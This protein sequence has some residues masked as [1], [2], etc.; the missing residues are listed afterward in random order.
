M[1]N[2]EQQNWIPYQM[3]DVVD[4]NDAKMSVRNYIEQKDLRCYLSLI[5]NKRKINAA[6]EFGC[7][8]GR[9]TQVLTEFASKVIGLEREQS[10]VNEA[11]TLIP[12]VTFIQVNDLSSKILSGDTFDVIITFT[13]LQHL[14]DEQAQ[15]VIKEM[16]RCLKTHGHILICEETDE[17]QIFGN[18]H[19][20]LGQ[21]TIARSVEKYCEY[22]NPLVLE[23]TA[24]RRIEPD[25][26]RENT[27][28]YMIFRK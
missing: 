8:Y 11:V 1:M 13:F 28:T 22:F 23:L 21:C 12:N 25:Y 9:M 17:T 5:N 3:K 20:P 26:P 2:S 15:K 6:A 16:I 19:D 27:G 7:G 4:V 24:P 14:I 18:I 10:F